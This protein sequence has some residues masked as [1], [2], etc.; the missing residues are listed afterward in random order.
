M[1]APGAVVEPDERGAD[2]QG[3]VHDLVDLLGEHLPQRA[4]EDGEVLREDEHL[5]AVDGA[6]AGDHAVGVGPLV[7]Q[8]GRHAMAGQH[9]EL[10][11]RAGVEQ[12]V[13]A[14]AGQQLALGVL[15]LDR[16][17]GPGVQRLF[18]A[19]VELLDALGHGVLRHRGQC[20]GR[21]GP[22]ESGPRRFTLQ[23]SALAL[24]L[25]K[26]SCEI[27]PASSSALALLIW[28]AEPLA[29]AVERT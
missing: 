11:E 2:R 22:D 23:D 7:D 27:V 21:R 20:T 5:A 28:S 8:V 13:D 19:L 12:V 25:S 17:L 16:A 4:T 14:L 10:V 3:Q 29:P 24:S 6:P 15:A 9:V 1:R 18:L 26:S